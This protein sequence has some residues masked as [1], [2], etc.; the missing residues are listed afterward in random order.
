MFNAFAYVYPPELAYVENR[1]SSAD[2]SHNE[3]VDSLVI[4]GVLGFLAFYFLMVQ[5][6]YWAISW[7]GWTPDR[8]A[9][10]RPKAT[11][12]PLEGI[13]VW[14]VANVLIGGILVFVGLKMTVSHWLHL[15][16]YVSLFIILAMLT[17][18]HEPLVR[19][20]AF[21]HCSPWFADVV[22]EG[23]STE[24]VRQGLDGHIDLAD[25]GY[26][27]AHGTSTEQGDIA[28]TEAV[29]AVFGD[30]ARRLVFGSTKSMTGHLLGAAGAVEAV[31]SILALRDQVSPPTINLRTPDP[32][33]DLDYVPNEARKMPIRVALSNSFGFGGTNGTLVLSRL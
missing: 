12:G 4:T 6:F 30:Q 31:F 1:G 5:V 26:I 23:L 29:K 2:R 20:A 33:C 15:N 18:A 10:Q 22:W 3:T 7:L 25:V 13:G 16:T 27:N 24:H 14:L 28:E 32:E 9:T 17:A 11:W 21:N 19:A 8:A